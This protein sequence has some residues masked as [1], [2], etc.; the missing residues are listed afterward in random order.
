VEQTETEEAN[1]EEEYQGV[2]EAMAEHPDI[3]FEVN[4]K[5]DKKIRIYLKGKLVWESKAVAA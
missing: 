2:Q 1:L 3:Y 4:S 5:Y